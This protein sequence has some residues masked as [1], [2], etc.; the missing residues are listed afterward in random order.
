MDSKFFVVGKRFVTPFASLLVFGAIASGCGDDDD[1]DGQGGTG[2]S[3]TSGGKGGKSGGAGKAGSAGRSSAGTT[4]EGGGEAGAL[5]GS[6]GVGSGGEAG[7]GSGGVSDSG[8]GGAA[9]SGGTSLEAGSGGMGGEAGGPDLASCI[10]SSGASCALEEC[11]PGPSGHV[12][13]V[14]I[15]AGWGFTCARSESGRIYCWGEST[16]GTLGDGLALTSHRSYTG[17]P[18]ANV[19]GAKRLSAGGWNAC[20]IDRDD[21]AL[22]WG[23]NAYDQLDIDPNLGGS[24]LPVGLNGVPPAIIDVAIGFAVD[25]ITDHGCVVDADSIVRCWGNNAFYQ[26]GTTAVA[27]SGTALTSPAMSGFRRVVASGLSSCGL[28]TD[29]AVQCWGARVYGQLGDGLGGSIAEPSAEPVSVLGLTAG[30]RALAA[31]SRTAC[32]VTASGGVKCWGSP[33]LG[34]LGVG[35]D[36]RQF[37]GAASTPVDVVGLNGGVSAIAAGEE[38]FC[39]L[40]E[41]NGTVQCWGATFGTSPTLVEGQAG[42]VA[43]GAGRDHTCV[44]PESGGV[45]CWGVTTGAGIPG[46]G[47][48]EIPQYVNGL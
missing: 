3:S 47:R 43:I 35:D 10:C 6:G 34:V 20:L 8:A 27:R 39:A 30:V 28:T 1:D 24:S 26:L 13:V 45:L 15:A 25:G 17:T 9:G 32:A 11:P 2:G 19:V 18:I 16:G 14:E 38:H 29:G 21:R 33:A 23:S 46:P 42:V 5:N 40:I 41:E 22:C 12:R 37:A 48:V 44:A 7:D 31:S 4:G 36:I